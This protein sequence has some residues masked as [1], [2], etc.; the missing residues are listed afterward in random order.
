MKVGTL[1]KV[2]DNKDVNSGRFAIVTYI[3]GGWTFPA[4]HHEVE[5]WCEAEPW[6]YMLVQL[7]VCSEIA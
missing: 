1:V 4:P 2:I 6:I 3:I 7:E 5:V